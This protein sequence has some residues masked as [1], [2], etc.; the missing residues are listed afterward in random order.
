MKT[1]IGFI[2][3]L[4]IG[5]LI[6]CILSSRASNTYLDVIK[7]DYYYKQYTAGN[8]AIKDQNYLLAIHHYKNL[9]AASSSNSKS[10]FGEPEK[11][12]TLTFPFASEILIKIKASSDPEGIGKMRSDAI[13]HGRLAYALEKYGMHEEAQT[14][15]KK[16]L[17]ML[18]L[19][20]INRVK[21]IIEKIIKT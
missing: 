1:I 10:I 16:A 21:Q 2:A 14:E 18:G 4:F 12:W 5:I 15:W 20:D 6:M 7:A 8:Q 13:D 17:K 3:G 11:V 9:V 19:K